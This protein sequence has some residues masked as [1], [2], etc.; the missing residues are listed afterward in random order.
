MGFYQEYELLG[1]VHDGPTKTLR[2][3][4]IA[5]DRA[6]FLHLLTG[7][8]PPDA[9]RTLLEHVN[10]L[11]ARSADVLRIGE[12]AGTRYVVTDVL[13]PF[14]NLEQW[15]SERILGAAVKGAERPPTKSDFGPGPGR[16]P[17]E[18]GGPQGVS[19]T[20]PPSAT[21]QPA[22]R[23]PQ[24]T[25]SS[26][27]FSGSP[28]PPNRVHVSP[29]TPFREVAEPAAVDASARDS[30]HLADAARSGEAQ[31]NPHVANPH[32]A[33]PDM[34]NPEMGP[35]APSAQEQRQADSATSTTTLA[36]G[37]PRRLDEAARAKHPSNG[38]DAPPVDSAHGVPPEWGLRELTDSL[39]AA[40]P[41]ADANPPYADVEMHLDEAS[42]QSDN[43]AVRNAMESLEGALKLRPDHAG[44]TPLAGDAQERERA[45]QAQEELQVQKEWHYQKA[46]EAWEDGD[47]E[48][49][50]D[51]LERL[52]AIENEQPGESERSGIYREFQKQVR[53]ENEAVNNSYAEAR[54]HM[55]EENLAE[56]LEI[57]ER[58]LAKFP[59]HAQFQALRFDIGERRR[60]EALAFIAD[61]DRL[62]N[63]EPNL[64]RKIEILQK[65]LEQS[66]G[67]KH[68]EE[69]VRLVREKQQLIRSIVDKAQ[70]L[71]QS[72]RFREA[73]EQWQLVESIYAPYPGLQ[74]NVQRLEQRVQEN[75]VRTEARARW[76]SQS[77]RC[78]QGGDYEQA[79]ELVRNALVE[80]P[81]DSELRQLELEAGEGLQRADTVRDHL[82]Q[83]QQHWHAGRHADGLDQLRQAQKIDPRNT[84]VRGEL[85][86]ALVELARRTAET[87]WATAQPMVEEIL[88][89]EPNHTTAVH[90][91]EQIGHQKREEMVSW[92]LVEARRLRAAGDAEAA[93]R[94]VS[95]NASLYPEEDRLAQLQAALAE[96]IDPSLHEA[97]AFREGSPSEENGGAGIA[98]SFGETPSQGWQ[99]GQESYTDSEIRAENALYGAEQP[100]GDEIGETYDT[101]FEAGRAEESDGPFG[102]GGSFESSE[103]PFGED[104]AS[105]A[106]TPL[107]LSRFPQDP[108]GVVE[109]QDDLL[110]RLASESAGTP[111][112]KQRAKVPPPQAG[113]ASEVTPLKQ[114]AALVEG[115]R[116]K[117][118]GKNFEAIGRTWPVVP[119]LLGV[120][121][122]FLLVA[123]LAI[124]LISRMADSPPATPPIAGL[125]V[126]I[127]S[128]P[129]GATFL[130]DGQTCVSPCQLDLA[131]QPHRVEANLAGFRPAVVS[132]DVDES[133]A[134]QPFVVALLPLVPGLHISSDLASGSVTLDG[135]AIGE[136]EDGGFE[137]ELADLGEGEH[138]LRLA[139][140]GSSAAFS[141]EIPAGGAPR[142]TTAPT[143]TSLKAVVIAGL[144]AVAHVYAT[145]TGQ[146][147][148]L[149]GQP[150]GKLGAEPLVLQNLSEGTHELTMGAG[151]EQRRV[152]FESGQAPLLAA[153]VNS[154]RNVGSLRVITGED[155][156][157]IFLN[158]TPYRRKTA[159]GRRLIYL[160]PNKFEVRVEK[161]GFRSPAVQ[162]AEIRKGEEVQLEFEL[163]PLPRTST[164]RIS[165]VIPGTEV[166]IDGQ[167][168]GT[169]RSAVFTLSSIEPGKHSIRLEH[170]DYQTAEFERE[171]APN[172]VVE[173]DGTLE[174]AV[175]TLEIQIIPPDADVRVT[176][177]REGESASRPVTERTL[178]LPP[179]TYT[180]QASGNGFQDYSAT[181]RVALGQTKTAAL[182]LRKEEQKVV[183]PAITLGDWE[184]AGWKREDKLLVRRGGDFVTLPNSGGAGRYTFTGLLQKGRRLEWVVNFTDKDNHV[185]Y[186]LGE[187]FLHR[188]EVTKGK[189]SRTVKIPHKMKWNDFLSVDI[190]VQGGSIVHRVL[191]DDQWIELDNWKSAGG[192]FTA[193]KFGFHIP[194]RDQVGL[195]HF[196]FQPER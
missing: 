159:R 10:A 63:E 55:A 172:A 97:N 132:F 76:V 179:G 67:E 101:S 153:F 195:S 94:L 168:R 86:N 9:Q 161:E 90:L 91:L 75:R 31:S 185:F 25:N 92:C 104:S 189:K 175:G 171:V 71:E 84:L 87:D 182:T 89:L 173:L 103:A 126:T 45:Q 66:P 133:S 23:S 129:P 32:V 184:K 27:T 68:F 147:V 41:E 60:Q 54:A 3:R 4:E 61:T 100:D 169:V 21:T 120:A 57:C 30:A 139:G 164:L 151:R 174:S 56:A 95:E 137:G 177:Q 119:T 47:L 48:A 113:P 14:S 135:K 37:S 96:Q 81:D 12:F 118:A 134:A 193:G 124:V 140:E 166:W 64:D 111:P 181:V 136:L 42:E 102:L 77:K 69:A 187:D 160:Y 1:L 46:R 33:N 11:R 156:V 65:A 35:A 58:Y 145:E 167:S 20:P 13:D 125:P 110:S 7:A 150:Q 186:Q 51:E 146:T 5:G 196:A 80:C 180:V 6:V 112:G 116:Q 170:E 52:S 149:D 36:D 83:A 72:H 108:R 40:A 28:S 122:A 143:V 128:S 59:N 115:L 190:G 98:Q 38:F 15:V 157:E 49:A 2:A 39:D 162:I 194:G 50:L 99:Q 43:E 93:Y 178:T 121:A 123:I 53:A 85:V 74:D 79:L 148:A 188:T 152:V 24:A 131:P 141:F 105:P 18:P 26:G 34:A 183:Q 73:L 127:Q 154:D 158:G 62:V 19:R 114:I 138:T 16:T 78:L 176:L 107:L 117:V 44:A 8:L 144:G 163:T 22:H 29:E 82:R 88:H 109:E 106:H 142:L 165:N 130:V 70:G 17:T 191:V 155:D 192:D